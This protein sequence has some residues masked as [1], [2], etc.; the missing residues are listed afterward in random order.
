M[1]EAVKEIHSIGRI[2]RD[3]KPDNFRVHKDKLYIIDF[4]ST[5]KCINETG[6]FS[7]QENI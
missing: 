4:G 3:V 2:H 6:N 5:Q 7:L 1:I